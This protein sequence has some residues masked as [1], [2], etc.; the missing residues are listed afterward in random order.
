MERRRPR[1][2]LALSN[3]GCP[4]AGS[5]RS[6]RRIAAQGRAVLGSPG[7]RAG[8]PSSS[9][10]LQEVAEPTPRPSKDPDRPSSTW[11]GGRSAD[12]KRGTAK[13]RG[14]E[15]PG[16]T[17]AARRSW[18]WEAF[19]VGQHTIPE[20]RPGRTKGP[21]GTRLGG[22][23][24]RWVRRRFQ[25]RRRR[26]S[27]RSR[28][29]GPFLNHRHQRAILFGWCVA[30]ET[31]NSLIASHRSRSDIAFDPTQT[32]HAGTQPI[33]SGT[34]LFSNTGFLGFCGSGVLANGAVARTYTFFRLTPPEIL[35]NPKLDACPP[36]AIWTSS[37]TGVQI[38][39]PTPGGPYPADGNPGHQFR[40]KLSAPQGQ[41]QPRK[42]GCAD[43]PWKA[44]DRRR[45]RV[46]DTRIYSRLFSLS[47][48]RT[49]FKL[50]ARRRLRREHQHGDHLRLRPAMSLADGQMNI[51][52]V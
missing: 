49:I 1:V 11:E 37:K 25:V 24:P 43:Q 33:R 35:A 41:V 3:A 51:T 38:S 2:P 29:R 34:D 26:F 7:K 42:A 9:A 16:Q 27:A 6:R 40:A 36:E 46:G 23:E 13:N 15:H 10:V 31:S 19:N 30:G 45:P 21:R 32:G 44:V 8:R 48:D 39:P 20:F 28:R 50:I 4:G 17:P 14:R 5:W 47:S 22:A 18:S 12:R 52:T